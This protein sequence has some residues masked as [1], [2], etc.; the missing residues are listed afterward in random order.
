MKTIAAMMM[1]LLALITINIANRWKNIV[2][3]NDYKNHQR[4]SNGTFHVIV[5]FPFIIGSAIKGQDLVGQQFKGAIM[6]RFID[7]DSEGLPDEGTNNLDYLWTRERRVKVELFADVIKQDGVPL[8]ETKPVVIGRKISLRSLDGCC[9]LKD[10]IIK[11]VTFP[12]EPTSLAPYQLS[13]EG[14]KK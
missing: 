8:W 5:T 14:L 6:A 2:E 13:T 10:G 11:N 3:A 9:F 7:D 4:A 12:N 1:F